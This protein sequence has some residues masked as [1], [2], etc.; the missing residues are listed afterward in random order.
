MRVT[1][2]DVRMDLHSFYEWILQENLGYVLQGE[3]LAKHTTWRVGGPADIF[4][5]PDN[6]KKCL[7]VIGGANKQGIP[8]TFLGGG[9]NVLIADEGLRG[10]VISTKRLQKLVW[11][12]DQVIVGAGMALPQLSYQF[13]QKDIRGL[14]FAA[15]IPGTVGGAVIMNAGAHNSCM[16]ELVLQVKTITDE[17]QSKDYTKN[18]LN[19]GYRTSALKNKKELVVE[20]GL[21]LQLGNNEEIKKLRKKYLEQRRIKQPINLPN[22]GSVFRNPPNDAAG[23]LIEA[24]GAK[25]WRI[26]DAKVSEK[27]AN[28]IVNLGKAKATDILSLIQEVRVAV[29][30]QF[31]LSLEPEVVLLGFDN[32]GR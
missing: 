7:Q 4:Y 23:R 6:W 16:E 11:E 14:E 22:A 20:I 24:V 26:G 30:Q 13:F 15:G 31:S 9:S 18:E 10:V 5:Q 8:V 27:H 32:N 29:A 28:F 1:K 17:G 12:K 2:D 21:K 19:F 3:L 25:G